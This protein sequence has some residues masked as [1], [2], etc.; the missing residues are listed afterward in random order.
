MNL[1]KVGPNSIK[2]KNNIPGLKSISS[3]REI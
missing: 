1:N 2:F 3:N